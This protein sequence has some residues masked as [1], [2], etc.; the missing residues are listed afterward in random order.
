[1]RKKYLE[2][3]R[4]LRYEAELVSSERTRNELYEYGVHPDL[5]MDC[6]EY[7]HCI[8]VIEF[9]W[10]Q[11]MGCWIKCSHGEFRGVSGAMSNPMGQSLLSAYKN[12]VSTD[13]ELCT[14]DDHHCFVE[15]HPEDV[16]ICTICKKVVNAAICP[17]D[18]KVSFVNQ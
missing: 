2:R 10:D 12:F 8:R 6:L 15:G 16:D 14:N 11:W 13:H 18:G 5:V 1:M 9:Q 17:V 3:V 7:F 4:P